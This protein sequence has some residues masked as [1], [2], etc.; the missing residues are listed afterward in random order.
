MKLP[1]EFGVQ[2]FFRL[3]VPGFFLACGLFPV[4]L[5]ILDALT[6]RRFDE[7]ALGAL[8]VACGW[9][10]VLADMPIYMLAEGRR[11][12][13][14]WLASA[15]Q[16]REHRRL[17]RIAT[18]IESPI[19]RTSLEASVEY[20]QFPLDSQGHPEPRFPTRLGNLIAAFEEYP[21]TRYGLDA[22]FFW[23]RIW[24]RLPEGTRAVLDGSQAV[25][26]SGVYSTICLFACSTLWS[27]YTLLAAFG[28]PRVSPAVS[29]PEGVGIVALSAAAAFAMYRVSVF[30]NAQYGELFKATFDVTIAR[31]GAFAKEVMDLEQV[32][33]LARASS[34]VPARIITDATRLSERDRIAVA[35]RYLHN[36]RIRCPKCP[37]AV[38]VPSFAA[39]LA[40]HDASR[41]NTP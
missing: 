16:A 9:L 26:D 30:A 27:V 4:L 40:A 14:A 24:L 36:Y 33:R 31:D 5:R 35:W 10:V 22:V 6:V 13:P 20:R 23:P 25:A 18:S 12:W 38:P 7:L 21:E 32:L 8:V 37:T 19:R 41:P 11:W 34:A 15:G 28:L 3:I 29:V 17:E 39:H 1:F 2:L